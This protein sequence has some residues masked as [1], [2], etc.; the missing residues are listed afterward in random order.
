MFFV[1]D[2]VAQILFI[3]GMSIAELSELFIRAGSWVAERKLE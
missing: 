1:R 2:V 3:I